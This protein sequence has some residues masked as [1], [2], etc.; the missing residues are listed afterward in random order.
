MVRILKLAQ[1]TAKD[2]ATV[3]RRAELEID[4]V[5]PI[6][7]ELITANAQTGDKSLNK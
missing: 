5:N 4:Q 7:Q 6:A 1:M 2:L 3:K